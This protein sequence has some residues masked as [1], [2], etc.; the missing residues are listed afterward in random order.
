MK[1]QTKKLHAIWYYACLVFGLLAIWLFID[2]ITGFTP[3]EYFF[4]ANPDIKK[5]AG[6]NIVSAWADFSF[7]TYHTIIFFAVWT[8]GLFL[9]FVTK[10]EKLNQFFHHEATVTFV[11]SNYVVTA[12]L[13][14]VFEL[15]SGAPTFG[16]YA[17]HNQAWHNFGTN[18]LGHYV[19]FAFALLIWVKIPT[20]GTM[21][22]GHVFLF[23][24]YLVAYYTSV[25]LTGMYAYQIEWYPYPIFDGELLWGMFGL[26]NYTIGKGIFLLVVTNAAIGIAYVALLYGVK[27]VKNKKGSKNI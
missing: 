1:K 14:T 13:Y 24:A 19:F 26:P 27:Q 9:S 4:K 10:S 21:K 8:I 22:K 18:I 2:H 16:L 23:V 17:F 15:A 5:Y 12:L 3:H 25:K 7:F 6:I 11:F 20:L